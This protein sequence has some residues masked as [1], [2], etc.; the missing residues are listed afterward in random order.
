MT[1]LSGPT[2]R[3]GIQRINVVEYK[4]MNVGY[5]YSARPAKF[6]EHSANRFDGEAQIIRDILTGHGNVQ[7]RALFGT[8]A[9]L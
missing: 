8:H 7:G 3:Q 4:L 5:A 6:A 2:F 1:S 9:L